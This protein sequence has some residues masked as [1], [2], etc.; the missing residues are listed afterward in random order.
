MNACRASIEVIDSHTEG[1]PTRVV[2]GGWPEPAGATMVERRDFM[3]REQDA[4][5]PRGRD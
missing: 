5:A 1:E 4:S 3:R 2:M